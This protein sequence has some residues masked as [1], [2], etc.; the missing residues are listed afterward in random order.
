MCA[1]LPEKRNGI[2][3]YADLLIFNYIFYH[4]T[5]TLSMGIRYWTLDS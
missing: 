2:K 3:I 4:F 5:L 1:T